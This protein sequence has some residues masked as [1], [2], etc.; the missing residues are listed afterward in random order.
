MAHLLPAADRRGRPLQLGPPRR[1]P[2]LQLSEL[3]I[4]TTFY[5]AKCDHE[6]VIR[7][8]ISKNEQ[9][10]QVAA[11]VALGAAEAVRSCLPR[12]WGGRPR[13]TQPVSYSSAA[14]A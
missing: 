10:S 9:S 11:V 13:P 8:S 2:S 4:L 3:R 5:L 7:I 6:L 1:P 14:D 12:A